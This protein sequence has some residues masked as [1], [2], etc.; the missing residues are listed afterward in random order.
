MTIFLLG[1]RIVETQI[2]SRHFGADT[3]N[4]LSF[5][6]KGKQCT[7]LDTLEQLKYLRELAQLPSYRKLWDIPL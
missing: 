4:K 6:N 5:L 3:R 2:I 1:S 7:H